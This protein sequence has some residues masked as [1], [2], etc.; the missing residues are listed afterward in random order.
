MPGTAL[1]VPMALMRGVQTSLRASSTATPT[2]G[3]GMEDMCS[4]TFAGFSTN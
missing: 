3:R 2:T 1:N 4:N